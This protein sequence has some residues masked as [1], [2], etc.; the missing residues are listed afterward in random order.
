[1][2]KLILGIIMVVMLVVCSAPTLALKGACAIDSENRFEVVVPNGS[3]MIQWSNDA[4]PN[5][6]NVPDEQLYWVGIYSSAWM[7]TF[8]ITAT[9][10]GH[11]LP[12]NHLTSPNVRKTG[13]G[14]TG[15]WLDDETGNT[16]PG[17]INKFT[18]SNGYHGTS[19]PIIYT[20]PDNPNALRSWFYQSYDDV[21]HTQGWVPYSFHNVTMGDATCWTLMFAVT[22]ADS[23]RLKFNGDALTG[24]GFCEATKWT[25]VAIHDVTGKV[26]NGVNTVEFDAVDDAYTH[27]YWMWLVGTTDEPDRD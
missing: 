14:T 20:D 24:S 2:N 18:S 25:H 9:W 19:I 10:N 5:N 8:P 16:T 17:A 22:C 23:G 1:M 27:P 26:Q 6:F 3:Y 15:F 4:P 13:C 12:T 21:S 11:Q 7:P